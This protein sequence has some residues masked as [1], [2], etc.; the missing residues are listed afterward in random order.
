MSLALFFRAVKTGAF[1]HYV[2]VQ[3]FPRKIDCFGF[4]VNRDFFSVYRNRT[5]RNNRFSVFGENG[6]LAAYFVSARKLTELYVV[7]L[8][9]I[10]L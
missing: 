3:R 1:Q 2:Y 5:R 9:R 8:S 10:V 7:T 4:G 6:F